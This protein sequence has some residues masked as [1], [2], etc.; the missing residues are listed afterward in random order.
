MTDATDAEVQ[1]ILAELLL[2]YAD[3]FAEMAHGPVPTMP[4]LIS[5][6]AN[7]G[8][9]MRKLRRENDDL[10]ATI[11]QLKTLG[12]KAHF[13]RVD[14][15]KRAEHWKANHDNQ[16]AIKRALAVR[17]D[18]PA[19]D[20]VRQLLAAETTRADDLAV[21]WRLSS[22]MYENELADLRAERDRLADQLNAKPAMQPRNT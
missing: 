20:G 14:A 8:E 19:H 2:Q 16:V 9:E 13:D 12:R 22:A 6:I 11:D 4:E 3:V 15:E 5:A 18:L 10:A 7:V 17:A 1:R 21:S